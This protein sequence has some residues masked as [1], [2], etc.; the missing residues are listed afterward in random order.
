M[1]LVANA[2]LNPSTNAGR[3]GSADAA[4]RRRSRRKSRPSCERGDTIYK[5]LCFS[6]HGDDGRGTPQPGAAAGMMMAPSLAGSPRV[7]GHRDYVIK[8]LLHGW[9]GP[10]TA[11]CT[12]PA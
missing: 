9:T 5:E 11:S 12:P 3:G 10:S 8:T 7:Q 2:I 6:C 1:Q 4:G